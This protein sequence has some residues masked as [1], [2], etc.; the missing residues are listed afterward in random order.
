LDQ[1]GIESDAFLKALNQGFTSDELTKFADL[2][3][4]PSHLDAIGTKTSED[5]DNYLQLINEGKVNLLIV[6][7]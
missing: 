5:L 4:K 7:M 3:F 6:Q 2:G 1:N